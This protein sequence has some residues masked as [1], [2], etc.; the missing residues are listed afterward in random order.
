[1]PVLGAAALFLFG[2]NFY[3]YLS[4]KFGDDPIVARHV[5]I[6]GEVMESFDMDFD[7]ETAFFFGQFDHGD[8]NKRWHHKEWT[9]RHWD[10]EFDA[11]HDHDLF[12]EA[13]ERHSRKIKE[14][15][16]RLKE[17]QRFEIRS[18]VLKFKS[19]DDNEIIIMNK[20]W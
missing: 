2:L 6:N 19:D 9:H 15:K 14:L 3:Q 10:H 20:S 18:K 8:H 1:M 5:V 13:H 7:A 11:N 16:E 12:E 4:A 17:R